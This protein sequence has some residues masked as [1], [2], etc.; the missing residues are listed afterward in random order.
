VRPRSACCTPMTA[1]AFGCWRW[2]A[3]P[4]LRRNLSVSG[5]LIQAALQQIVD[6]ARVVHIP[7]VVDTGAYLSGVSS[8]L[9]FV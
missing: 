9:K 4:P 8:R 2:V 6:G 3:C 7:D 1:S 5:C